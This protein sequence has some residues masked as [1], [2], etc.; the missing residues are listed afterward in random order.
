MPANGQISDTVPPKLLSGLLFRIESSGGLPMIFLLFAVL[1]AAAFFV[2]SML[3]LNY[4]RQLGLRYLK[5]ETGIWQV[6]QPW[7]ALFLH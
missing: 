1:I 5:Q 3:L 2:C 4:G 6:S 7:K